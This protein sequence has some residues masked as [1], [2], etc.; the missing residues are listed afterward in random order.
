ME[1]LNDP[2]VSV[3]DSPEERGSAVGIASGK[4][5]AGFQEEPRHF[6]PAVLRCQMQRGFLGSVLEIDARTSVHEQ[7]DSSL[8][9]GIGRIHQGRPPGFVGGIDDYLFALRQQFPDRLDLSRRCPIP[10]ILVRILD[11][12]RRGNRRH[13]EE[14]REANQ[15]RIAPGR[16]GTGYAQKTSPFPTERAWPR[17]NGSLPSLAPVSFFKTIYHRLG[18]SREWLP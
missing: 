15:D 1:Q 17:G 16:P 14:T 4:V 13:E 7:P 5:S 6:R 8:V 10:E 11:G 2:G 9:S 3:F 12:C 18:P